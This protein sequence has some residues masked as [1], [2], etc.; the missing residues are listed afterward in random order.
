[1][2]QRGE[3]P[4]LSVEAGQLLRM[5]CELFGQ[6]FDGDFSPELAVPG[7]V[8]LSHATRTDGGENLVGT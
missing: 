1:M 5:L 8:D 4:R 2:V 7:A 3:Q 6:Y